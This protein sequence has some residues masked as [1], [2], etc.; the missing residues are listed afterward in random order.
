MTSR[1]ISPYYYDQTLSAL[2]TAG[3]TPHTVIEATSIQAQLGYV[4]CGMGVSLAP[5]SGASSSSKYVAWVP[6]KQ[7]IIS[8]ELAVAWAS[9]PIPQALDNFL[10]IVR[11]EAGPGHSAVAIQ[12]V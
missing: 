12:R 2:A 10:K 3:I 6:L 4:A 8:T 5:T 9:G 7:E 11:E 1:H